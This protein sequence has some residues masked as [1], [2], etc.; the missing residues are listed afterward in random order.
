LILQ[1]TRTAARGHGIPIGSG[2]SQEAL[3]RKVPDDHISSHQQGGEIERLLSKPGEIDRLLGF[4]DQTIFNVKTTT[5]QPDQSLNQQSGG[6]NP[7]QTSPLKPQRLTPSH[8]KTVLKIGS[9]SF[10]VGV[11]IATG[12]FISQQ[13]PA[14]SSTTAIRTS[15]GK[16]PGTTNKPVTITATDD[17]WVA[18]RSSSTSIVYQG[19]LKRGQTL[20][21]VLPRGFAIY[22]GRPEALKIIIAGR[23]QQLTPE[24]RW[25]SFPMNNNSSGQQ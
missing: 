16:P 18:I 21:L 13:S 8:A 1:T 23:E 19:I 11:L 10:L 15:Q 9:S 20:N 2:L 5:I 7:T 14:L 3:Q 12:Q 25:S 17:C 24:L 22:P 4:T 6:G